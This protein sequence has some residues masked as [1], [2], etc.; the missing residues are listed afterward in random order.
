MLRIGKRIYSFDFLSEKFSC[1]LERC[2]GAC[3]VH[4]DSGAPLEIEETRILDENFPAIKPFLRPEA[5]L[6][7]E[8]VG[9]HVID[10]DTDI[11]TPLLNGK[12]CAYT[13]FEKGI[14]RCGIEKAWNAGA[15][16]FRKPLSCH[17]YPIRKTRYKDFDA[18][19]YHQWDLCKP[20]REN[21]NNLDMPVYEFCKDALQR[22]IGNEEFEELRIARAKMNR[23]E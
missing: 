7:I 19:N 22:D 11:V 9:K 3:C 14:A 8:K 6:F 15:I 21:G 5:A 18:Y 1:D 16:K 12:E 10:S 4:G 2:H 20:A 17:L 23:S 13:V